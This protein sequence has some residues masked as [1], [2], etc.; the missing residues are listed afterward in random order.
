MRRIIFFIGLLFCAVILLIPGSVAHA[1]DPSENDDELIN[2]SSSDAGTGTERAGTGGNSTV[3]LPDS[4]SGEPPPPE[5]RGNTEVVPAGA[6]G[7]DTYATRLSQTGSQSNPLPT[8]GNTQDISGLISRLTGILGAIIPFIIA[9]AV[10][11]IL[12][13]IFRYISKAGEE[14]ARQEARQFIVWGIIGLFF[15]V[16]IWGFVNLLDKTFSLDKT[17]RPS[18]IPTVPLLAK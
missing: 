18:D 10:V 13:G 17:I 1:Q 6:R 8:T 9:L 12:W 11:V 5:P 3:L 16:S 4:V 14:E 2:S 15:M 7:G